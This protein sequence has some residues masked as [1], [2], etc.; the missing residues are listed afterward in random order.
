MEGFTVLFSSIVEYKGFP[1]I[2]KIAGREY[3]L[4]FEVAKVVRSPVC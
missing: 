3:D 2:C 4:S 1:H